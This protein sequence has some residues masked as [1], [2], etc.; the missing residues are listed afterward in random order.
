MWRCACSSLPICQNSCCLGTHFAATSATPHLLVPVEAEDWM[1]PEE[2]KNS[3]KACGVAVEMAH[4]FEE[5][6]MWL[7]ARKEEVTAAIDK[8]TSSMCEEIRRIAENA[9][10]QVEAETQ[11]ALSL[12]DTFSSLELRNQ[13]IRLKSAQ[14]HLVSLDFH[15]RKATSQPV[16]LFSLRSACETTFKSAEPSRDWIFN[17]SD[18]D[19]LTISASKR[20]YLLGI[21]FGRPIGSPPEVRRLEISSSKSPTGSILYS[22][23]VPCVL[24][25]P[26]LRLTQPILLL[27]GQK[28]TLKAVLAGDGIA[29]GS[30]CVG[31]LQE[32]LEI[33]LFPAQFDPGEQNNGTNEAEG[34]FLEFVYRLA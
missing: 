9:K 30:S 3:L 26:L 14:K 34:I 24:A 23:P 28:Y 17:G 33:K 21:A 5:E 4:F 13:I 6:R 22:H 1:P 18:I 2:A 12:L 20:I 27:P 7:Q 11:K 15:I 10:Q 25:Q 32:G 19:A 29:A 16:F 8:E 31:R